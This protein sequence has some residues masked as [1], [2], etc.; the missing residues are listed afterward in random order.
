MKKS[1]MFINFYW[2][3][4]WRSVLTKLNLLIFFL[5][6]V[7]LGRRER[8]RLS[9]KTNWGKKRKIMGNLIKQNL[10]HLAHQFRSNSCRVVENFF[11]SSEGIFS[12]DNDFTLPKIGDFHEKRF[13][14]R[15]TIKTTKLI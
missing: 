15:N 1:A 13:V 6:G 3:I 7:T 10:F 2:E 8:V 5:T 12:V 11:T 9:I 14:Y 4:Q